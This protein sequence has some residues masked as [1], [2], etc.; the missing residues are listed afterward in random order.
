MQACFSA[1]I[2]LGLVLSGLPHA[3]CNCGCAE[4]AGKKSEPSCRSCCDSHGEQSSENPK[5]CKCRVCRVVK[6]VPPGPMAKAP[7]LDRTSSVLPMSAALNVRAVVFS[8]SEKSGGAILSQA[9]PPPACGLP[10]LL[11]HLLF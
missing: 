8:A 10:I 7:S 4:V 9:L 11:G 2:V 6:A 1:V 3:F 5:P